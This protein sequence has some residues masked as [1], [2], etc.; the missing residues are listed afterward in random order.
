ML[1]S[2][3]AMLDYSWDEFDPRYLSSNECS[4]KS[5][6]RYKQRISS[7]SIIHV[8]NRHGEQ[9]GGRRKILCVLYWFTNIH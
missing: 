2:V 8:V 1:P 7:S 9:A 5:I 6:K 4:G 3:S